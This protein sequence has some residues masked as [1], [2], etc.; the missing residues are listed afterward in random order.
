MTSPGRELRTERLLLRGWLEADHPAFA[1]LNADPEVMRHFPATLTREE[2]DAMADRIARAFDERSW[3]LW[4]VEHQGD[5]LGFAGLSV[6]RFEAHFTP[7]VEIGWRLAKH[8]WGH[9][10][11]TEAAR[12]VLRFAF[13]ELGLEEVVSFTTVENARSRAVMERIGMTHDPADDF[14]HPGIPVGSP[15]RRHVLYRAPRDPRS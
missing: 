8:A 7:A 10:Y 2:S 1:A 3:G 12:A 9:G 15:L 4:A 14:D 11:A 13:D 6:P 5:F